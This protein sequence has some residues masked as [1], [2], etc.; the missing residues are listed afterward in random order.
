MPESRQGLRLTLRKTLLAAVAIGALPLS[1]AAKDLPATPEGAQ[2][3]S[4]VF[5]A[6][7]GKPAAGAP[8]A[9]SVTPE[10]AHYAVAVDLASFAAPLKGSGFSIDPATVK[11]MLTE[12]DDGTWHVAGAELPP[13]AAHTKD[14]AVAYNFAGYKFDGIFDPALAAFKSAQTG[15]DKMTAKVEALAVQETIAS[16]PVRATQAAT[17]A[18]NGAVSTTVHEEIADLSVAG[19]TTPDPAK[20]GADAKPDAF[21]FQLAKAAVDV[22]LDGAPVRKALDL[23]AFVVAHPSRP[24]IAANEPAF[25]DLLRAVVPADAKVAEKVDA[26]NIAVATQKGSFGLVSAKFS[27]AAALAR[28]PKGSVEYHLAM[29]GLTLPAGLVPPPMHDL[30]PTAFDFGVKASGFDFADGA[31]E[32]IDD[33]H[34]AGD[35]PLIAEADG[36][37]ILA[38]MKGTAPLTVELLP[39]HVA[40]PQLDLSLEGLVHLEGVRPS[41]T[42]KVR[43]R[44]FDK[45]VAALKAVG[46]MASPQLIGFLALA[47]GLGKAEGDGELTWVAEYGSDGSIKING[48]PLGKGP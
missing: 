23:W 44:N 45:T 34:F 27:L 2:K 9:I 48:L 6:Y 19:A 25:K 30:A 11:Y 26:Q 41:G 14:G 32:A 39:S 35:G 4:A 16:G 13:I 12:Q 29:D 42:L 40:A 20:A 5:A 24:E 3:L 17:P 36:A 8:P 7:L 46:P 37:K 22:G 10:G 18:P 38:R 31:D 1:A 43:A 15:V 28:G 47:K 21:T 33:L